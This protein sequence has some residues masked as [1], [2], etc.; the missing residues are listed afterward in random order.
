MKG[1]A[2]ARVAKRREVFALP[3][4]TAKQR[5]LTTERSEAEELPDI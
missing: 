1:L 5:G 3:V 4:T 2:K